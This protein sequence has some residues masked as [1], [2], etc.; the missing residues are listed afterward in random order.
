MPNSD[1]YTIGYCQYCK[2]LK[3]LK[4]EV[5][6]DCREK[7]LPDFMKDLFEGFNDEQKEN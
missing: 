1:N 7:E 2:Q 4:N 6:S 3:A 5:C